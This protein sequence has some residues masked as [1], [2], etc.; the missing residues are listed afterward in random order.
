MQ[1]ERLCDCVRVAPVYAEIDDRVSI[2]AP[3]ANG[4]EGRT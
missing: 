3:I 4:E 2:G 1:D